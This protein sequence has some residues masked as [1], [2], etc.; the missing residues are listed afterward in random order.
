MASSSLRR[1][2]SANMSER[3]AR[4][5]SSPSGVSMSV[6]ELRDHRGEPGCPGATTAREESSALMTGTPSSAKPLLHR[7]LAAC[8]PAREADTQAPRH[9]QCRRP[10][11][12]K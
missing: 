6:A 11:T 5:S 9:A 7:A 10:D 8:D 12:R 2:G 4:R 1:F 3:S